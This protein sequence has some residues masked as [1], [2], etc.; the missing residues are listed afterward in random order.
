MKCKSCNKR[1]IA[2]TSN[3]YCVDCRVKSRKASWSKASKKHYAE[4]HA[5]GTKLKACLD[6]GG[7]FE[8]KTEH[9]KFDSPNCRRKY[10]YRQRKTPASD[11]ICMWC[12]SLIVRPRGTQIFCTPECR[13][14]MNKVSLPAVLNRPCLVC[15]TEFTSSQTA[16]KYCS[17]KCKNKAFNNS[18]LGFP[19]NHNVIAP[20]VLKE[21]DTFSKRWELLWKLRPDLQGLMMQI[22]QKVPLY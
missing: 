6:C 1:K 9:H 3:K 2:P 10:F 11:R 4:N 17:M 14:K 18:K 16:R 21:S 7:L 8:S 12:K 20:T 13:E 15:N 19:V 5:V 22:E